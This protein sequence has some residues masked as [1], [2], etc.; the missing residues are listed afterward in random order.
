MGRSPGSVFSGCG[1]DSTFL[2]RQEDVAAN[3]GHIR[4]D[5]GTDGRRRRRRVVSLPDVCL[6]GISALVPADTVS[7]DLLGPVSFTGHVEKDA[8]AHQLCDAGGQHRDRRQRDAVSAHECL[9]DRVLSAD[10]LSDSFDDPDHA[11]LPAQPARPGYA[12]RFVRAS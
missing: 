8:P 7:V 11:E 5:G 10:G 2:H 12:A 4:S 6:V 9:S 3:V 1:D